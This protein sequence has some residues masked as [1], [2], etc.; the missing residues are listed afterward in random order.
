MKNNNI[1]KNLS[2]AFLLL[3]ALGACTEEDSWIDVNTDP[4]NPTAVTPDLILPQAQIFTATMMHDNRRVNHLGNMMMYNWSESQGF[5]WYNDEFQY[6]VTTTF[7]SGIFD[8]TYRDV[9]KQ[10]NL[11]TKYG[12]NYEAYEGIGKVMMAYH[13]Q[14]L[15]DL[16]GDI[17]YSEALQRSEN[18]SPSYDAAEDVYEGLMVDLSDAITLFESAENNGIAVLPGTDDVM[19]AGD[20]TMWKQFANTIKVRILTRMS[21][22]T[23]M[24]TYIQTQLDEIAA[25]GSGYITSAVEVDPGYSDEAT[26]QNPYWAELGFTPTGD[27]QLNYRATCATQYILDY[28]SGTNDPRIDYL[29]ELPATGHLGVE[30]GVEP[31]PEFAP[32]FVSNIG[33]GRL[34]GADMP[35]IIFSA[36]E[37]NFNLAELAEK[38]FGGSAKAYFDAGILASFQEL[39]HENGDPFAITED[40]TVPPD[41]VA[42]ASVYDVYVAQSSDLVDYDGSANKIEAIITQKWIA[43]NGIS[44][45]QSWFDYNRTGYPSN[46]PVSAESPTPDRPVRLFYPASET[47]TNSGNVPNQPNAFTEKIFWAN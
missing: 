3:F 33:P 15:T 38:G 8:E 39:A 24:Q 32:E 5:S 18:P 45:E 9:L 12:E 36:A 10:Y 25:E 16:Y 1:L 30:Q 29:Y 43:L 22:M 19:F 46:L 21:D 44:A 4:N 27:E 11:L 42:D 20:L 7:Y 6:L 31:G 28:L 41:G 23:S 13:F 35:S 2:F 37:S 34:K 14:I 47:A 26:K 17:P 40:T